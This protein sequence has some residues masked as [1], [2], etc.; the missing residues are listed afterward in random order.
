[1]HVIVT[2]RLAFGRCLSEAVLQLIYPGVEIIRKASLPAF[3][4]VVHVD[5]ELICSPCLLCCC[6]WSDEFELLPCQFS[7]M[8]IIKHC[9]FLVIIFSVQG[10]NSFLQAVPFVVVTVVCV[11]LIKY[12]NYK[13]IWNQLPSSQVFLNHTI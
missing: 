7:G 3:L 4:D 1:M 11:V 6:A 2:L 5:Q 8:F 12:L 13:S 10:S 9:L